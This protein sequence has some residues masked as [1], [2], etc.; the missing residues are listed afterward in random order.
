MEGGGG[1]T[2]LHPS[3]TAPTIPPTAPHRS[4]PRF[5]WLDADRSKTWADHD[6]Q[7]NSIASA[8]TFLTTPPFPYEN[9]PTA[10][11]EL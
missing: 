2:R 1:A 4:C 9:L 3:L 6:P 7:D 11:P 8:E 10:S 5:L